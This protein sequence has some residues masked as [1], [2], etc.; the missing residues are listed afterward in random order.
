MFLFNRHLFILLHIFDCISKKNQLLKIYRS[1]WLPLSSL[2]RACFTCHCNYIWHW[3][4]NWSPTTAST[5]L[6][7]FNTHTQKYCKI[8][9][10]NACFE[11]ILLLVPTFSISTSVTA[12]SL[13]LMYF[14][15][16]CLKLHQCHT[17]F[18][19]PPSILQ[20]TH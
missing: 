3:S 15:Y 7:R 9:M 12:F 4:K 18:P 19:Y 1:L 16:L 11:R 14:V 17:M 5:R 13:I 2:V 6:C 10:I 20:E 8:F